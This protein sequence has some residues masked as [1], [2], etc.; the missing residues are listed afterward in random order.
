MSKKNGLLR[1]LACFV[2]FPFLFVAAA[3]DYDECED[4]DPGVCLDLFAIPQESA[5]S[6]TLQKDSPSI[7]FFSNPGSNAHLIQYHQSWNIYSQRFTS[8][9]ILSVALR[10]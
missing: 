8:E 7:C 6:A 3:A 4:S 2:L 9:L 5:A 10:C 1:V